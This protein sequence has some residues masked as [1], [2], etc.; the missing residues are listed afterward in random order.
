MSLTDE[1]KLDI[2]ITKFQVKLDAQR[3]GTWDDFKTFLGGLTKTKIKVFIQDAL[4][5][6]VDN[7]RTEAS[8][9]NTMAD[10]EESLKTEIGGL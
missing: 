8:D 1:Q 2:V 7:L 6:Q 9:R 3:Q 5:T 4:Q 10:D